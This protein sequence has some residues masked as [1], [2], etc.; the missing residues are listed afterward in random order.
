MNFIRLI[1]KNCLF[2]DFNDEE[3]NSLFDCMKGRIIMKSKGMLVAKEDSSINELCIILKG[4]VL[5]FITKLNGKKEPIRML[6]EGEMFGLHQYYL[7]TKQLGFNVVAAT[8]VTLLYLDTSTIVTMCDK[9]CAC[10]QELIFQVMRCLSKQIEE[11]ENNN[12][13]IMIRGM[14]QKIAKLIYDKYLET[15]ETIIYLGMD[16]NEMARYLNVSRPSMSREMM[17]MRDE[18][19]FEFWK[20]KI[21]IKDIKQLEATIKEIRA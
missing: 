8:D 21:T 12:N 5:M 1:K 10:H 7:P 6:N 14:R 20:D 17:R 4:E 13:Y 16:R 19:M 18:G 11:L 3:I 9:A 15:K 2:R